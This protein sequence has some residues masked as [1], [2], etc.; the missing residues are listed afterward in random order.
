MVHDDRPVN[1]RVE[2][3]RR[4]DGAVIATWAPGVVAPETRQMIEWNGLAGGARRSRGAT[5]SG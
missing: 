3:V 4:S 1:V 5:R 2:L